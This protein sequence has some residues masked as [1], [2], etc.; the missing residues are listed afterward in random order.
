VLLLVLWWSLSVSHLCSAAVVL[1][2]G[3]EVSVKSVLDVV[4][5]SNPPPPALL[6][7]G[8]RR[9]VGVVEGVEGVLVEVEVDEVLFCRAMRDRMEVEGDRMEG[10]GCR[11]DRRCHRY[12]LLL[13]LLLFWWLLLLLFWL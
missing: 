2:V 8:T 12:E 4:R 3:V 11:L 13:L 10:V 7:L 5:A 9:R 6:H 1:L